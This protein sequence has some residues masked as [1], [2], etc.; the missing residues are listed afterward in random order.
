MRRGAA[1]LFVVV[2][3]LTSPHR[4]PAETIVV[5]G[6]CTL[7]QA[8]SAANNDDDS[9]GLCPP[10]GSGADILQMTAD[11][12]L[13]E[14]VSNRTGLP[15]ITSDITIHGNGLK[16]ERDPGA[17]TFRLFR[18][19]DGGSLTLDNVTVTGGEFGGFFEGGA[20][21]NDGGE[22]VL[23]NTTLSGNGSSPLDGYGGA[24]WTSGSST[25][26]LRSSTLID[27][28][29]YWG[30]G[31]YNFGALYVY[32]STLSEHYSFKYGAALLNRG[33]ASFTNSTLAEND[34]IEDNGIRNQG[35]LFLV[36]ST[37][38][39][40]SALNN[41][42]F[43]A[44]TTYL[45][46]TVIWSCKNDSTLV[47]GGNN[48]STNG[49]C[50][51]ADFTPGVDIEET[52][53]DNGGPTETLALLSGSV[54]ADAAGDCGLVTD[55]RGYVRDAT[56]DS[57]AY[58][59]DALPRAAIDVRGTCPGTM[60]VAVTNAVPNSELVIF[61]GGSAGASVV[62]P[63]ESC[64]GTD[65]DI[66]NP[67]LLGTTT[68]DGNGV[69]GLQETFFAPDCGRV[70]QAV[71]TSGCRPSNVADID[72]C[73]PLA[74]SH[75]GAGSHPVTTPPS[76]AGCDFG[77]F[78]PNELVTLTAT[79]SPGWSVSGWSGTDD[80][81]STELENQLTMPSADH[82][83]TVNYVESAAMGPTMALSGTCPGLITIDVATSDPNVDVIL[84][85]GSGPGST[86]LPSGGCAGTE[87]D[88]DRARR[89]DGV[90]TDGS[91]M[92]QILRNFGAPWCGR[93]LQAI[94][95]SCATG[96][97]EQIP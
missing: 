9:G 2:L 39:P 42:G 76:S 27:N 3:G 57:G 46:D 38:S 75:T 16:V 64:A 15:T 20:I 82:E 96:N 4:T 58:E 26:T 88:L 93:F 47:D 65:L 35:T 6:D 72:S 95:R 49:S 12:T 5:A 73:Q 21:K 83:V 41:D 77:E 67:H 32:D 1:F 31:I 60:T 36:N 97:F 45:Y 59:L 70:V 34:A 68:T 56:C 37:L 10:G 29:A 92:G 80:D 81:A 7:I 91:G 79:P 71:D 94:D 8:I 24:I 63:G 40:T 23:T 50:F 66:T 52:L 62:P 53:A 87:L 74:R 86:V 44:A 55:Q 78:V 14:I 11:A 84:Y 22:L 13:T 25:T 33:T 43:Y 19:V 51:G 61:K 18:I 69:G 90:T 17:V 85:A 30:A 28:Q 48:F 54:I 89:I